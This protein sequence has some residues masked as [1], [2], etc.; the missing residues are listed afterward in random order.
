MDKHNKDHKKSDK[1]KKKVN[2]NPQFTP[3]KGSAEK[4]KTKKS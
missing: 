4:T 3:A 1:D 2:K